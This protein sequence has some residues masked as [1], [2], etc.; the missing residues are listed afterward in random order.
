MFA[1]IGFGMF[2]LGAV[3][4]A[5]VTDAA[6]G[7]F[8]HDGATQPFCQIIIDERTHVG[9][10]GSHQYHEQNVHGAVGRHRQKGRGWN[11]YFRRKGNE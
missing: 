9:S 2:H 11:H 10:Q 1:E 3:N 7:K 5:H 4:Q 8:I 6:I